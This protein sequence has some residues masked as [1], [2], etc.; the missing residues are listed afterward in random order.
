MNELLTKVPLDEWEYENAKVFFE[1]KGRMFNFILKESYGSFI[2]QY[3]IVDDIAQ[4]LFD[5]INKNDFVTNNGAYFVE[6]NCDKDKCLFDK[7]VLMWIPSVG[8]DEICRGETRV[9][10]GKTIIKLR[11]FKDELNYPNIISTFSHEIMHCYQHII[12]DIDGVYKESMLLYTNLMDFMNG[13]NPIARFSMYFF[14]GLYMCFSIERKANISS[15]S[16]YLKEYFKDGFK[17]NNHLKE[18]TTVIRDNDK[19]KEYQDIMEKMTTLRPNPK[20]IEYITKCL[21]TPIIDVYNNNQIHPLYNK[22]IFKPLAFINRNRK[23]IIRLCK[24]TMRKMED[25][26]ALYLDKEKLN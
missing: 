11:Y 3:E 22:D 19:Y 15:L 20:D 13:A 25:N 14:Y 24:Y 21:T 7:V 16:N 23:R 1:E 10:N 26:A 6:I 18:F 4:Q 9:E 8:A 17:T 2:N 5:K 12:K